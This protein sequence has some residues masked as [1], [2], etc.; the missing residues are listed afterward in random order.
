[1]IRKKRRVRGG[2]LKKPRV[3]VAAALP[4]AIPLLLAAFTTQPSAAPTVTAAITTPEL[5][6][7]ELSFSSTAEL[8]EHSIVLRFEEEDTL[9][10]VLTAGGVSR[11]DSARLT[12]QFG[13]SIDLRR[14]RPG[15][16]LRFHRDRSGNVD[17]VQMKVIGWGDIQAIRQ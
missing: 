13:Q 11:G 9:D 8:P 5:R 14:L 2:V 10:A 15:H 6:Y 3:Y 16:L 17:A 7:D 1:M 4:V 12:N